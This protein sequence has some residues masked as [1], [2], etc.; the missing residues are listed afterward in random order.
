MFHGHGHPLT[1]REL[2]NVDQVFAVS[3]RKC[4]YRGQVSAFL[5]D[6]GPVTNEGVCTAV[7]SKE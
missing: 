7:W 4:T 2:S 5:E 3:N 1:V 6:S